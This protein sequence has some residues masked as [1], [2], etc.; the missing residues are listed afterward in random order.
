MKHHLCL[1]LCC[2]NDVKALWFHQKENRHLSQCVWDCISRSFRSWKQSSWESLDVLHDLLIFIMFLFSDDLAFLVACLNVLYSIF[3]D[4]TVSFHSL[5]ILDDL[6]ALS[7]SSYFDYFMWFHSKSESLNDF[8]NAFSSCFVYLLMH[9]RFTFWS[10]SDFN[11]CSLRVLMNFSSFIVFQLQH[12]LRANFLQTLRSII[13]CINK[14]FE[15][16]FIFLSILHL[17]NLF[18]MSF[19]V[20]IKSIIV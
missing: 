8:F 13:V 11:I 4:S 16:F 10:D 9:W 5:Y 14:W 6:H 12:D 7:H 20:K 3:D 17:I 19:V 15:K 2:H 1:I 18:M